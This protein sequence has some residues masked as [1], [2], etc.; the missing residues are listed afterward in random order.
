M[1]NF[2]YYSIG[3]GGSTKRVKGDL[4]EDVMRVHPRNKTVSEFCDEML[5]AVEGY[6][7]TRFSVSIDYDGD[8]S[9]FVHGYRPMTDEE[10]ELVKQLDR[11]K[12]DRDARRTLEKQEQKRQEYEALKKEFGDA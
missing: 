1:L 7:D 8:A 6:V 11:E 3:P 2:R 9:Y 10:R 5:T 4:T 12:L